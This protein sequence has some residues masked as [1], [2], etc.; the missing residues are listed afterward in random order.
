[1][2]ADFMITNNSYVYFSTNAPS[3]ECFH[4]LMKWGRSIYILL[5]KASL[6]FLSFEL[7]DHISFIL[8]EKDDRL[9][10]QA[11]WVNFQILYLLM[12]QP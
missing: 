5:K 6:I 7:R 3:V 8:L 4:F 9:C 11:T 2:S 12:V 10:S 1:M